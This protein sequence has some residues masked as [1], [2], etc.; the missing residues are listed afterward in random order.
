M[1]D[2]DADPCYSWILLKMAESGQKEGLDFEGN[3]APEE[4]SEY[5]KVLNM[6]LHVRDVVLAVNQTYIRSAAMTEACSA[7]TKRYMGKRVTANRITTRPPP[8]IRPVISNSSSVASG[9]QM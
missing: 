5:L 6:L 7:R 2:G 4:I 8:V 9:P 3:H 1:K